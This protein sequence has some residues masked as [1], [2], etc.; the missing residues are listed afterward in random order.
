MV[1]GAS[2]K[3]PSLAIKRKPRPSAKPRWYA[4]AFE[5][6]STRSRTRPRAIT[7]RGCTAPL[8]SIVWPFSPA[9]MSCIAT[10][11]PPE[12]G[13]VPSAKNRRSWITSGRSSTP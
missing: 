10:V 5:P 12:Y 3:P 2:S 4:R 11:A 7:P 9:I 8:T 1:I 6:L 13:W